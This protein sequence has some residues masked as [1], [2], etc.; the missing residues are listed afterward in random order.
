MYLDL[1]SEDFFLL[2]EREKREKKKHPLVFLSTAR[3]KEK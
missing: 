2:L 1:Y 3:L